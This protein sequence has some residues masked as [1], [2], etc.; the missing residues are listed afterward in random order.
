MEVAFVAFGVTAVVI[1]VWAL[2]LK[3]PSHPYPPGPSRLPLI[4]NLL[5]WPFESGWVKFTQWAHEYGDIV[6]IEILGMHIAILNTYEVSQALLSQSMYSDRPYLAMAG[7]LMGFLPSIILAPY[8]DHWKAMRKLTQKYLN[9]S[10]SRAFWDSQ[11]ADARLLLRM[12]LDRPEDYRILIPYVV[13]KNIVENAYGLQ[14]DSPSSKYIRLSKQTHDSIQHAVMPGSFVVDVF[15]ILRHIPAWFPGAGFKKL[16]RIARARGVEMVNGAF[17]EVKQ[18]MAQ[19]KARDSLAATLLR[20]TSQKQGSDEEYEHTVMWAVG[21]LYG[22]GT[23]SNASSLATFLMMMAMHPDIQAKAHEELDRVVGS[24]RLPA[25]DDRESLPYID[26]IVKETLRYHPPT[27]MGIAHRLLKDDV[28]EGYYLP[29]GCIVLSN[30]WGM[31][32]DARRYQDP[33]SFRPER[34]LQ[35]SEGGG[36]PDPTAQVFGFGRRACPGTHY[37]LATLYITIASLL[38]TYDIKMP[39][40]TGAEQPGGPG[41]TGGFVSHPKKFSCQISPRSPAAEALIRA[42]KD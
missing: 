28:Y 1:A 14:I 32:R 16:A 18:T 23:E 8:G 40:K 41:F 36:E 26:A 10:A 12:L 11:V 2:F 17:N 35:T 33:S 15:P 9:K 5:D 6:H 39:E 29:K 31:S 30:I 7:D 19:G 3:R 34:F 25:M 38:A 21:S 37:S 4:G 20:D 27:P 22:A 13:G 24:E 42:S